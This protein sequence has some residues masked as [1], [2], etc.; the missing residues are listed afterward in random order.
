MNDSERFIKALNDRD[1]KTIKSVPKSDTH[2]HAT[3]GG[4]A[5]YVLSGKV[6]Q[7]PKIPDK[8]PNLEYMLEWYNEHFEPYCQGIE[9]FER[10]IKGAFHQALDDGITDLAL[11]FNISHSAKYDCDIKKYVNRLSQLHQEV[12]PNINFY[13]ELSFS[14][15][16]NNEEVCKTI[17]L[18]LD[19]DFFTSIDLKGNEKEPVDNY[20]EIFK[21]AKNKGLKTKAHVGEFGNPSEII[22]VIEKLNLDEVHHGHQAINS[23]DIMNYLKEKKI[24]LN[25]CPTSNVV[26]GN[27][28]EY[29]NHPIGKLYRYGIPV[30]IN[31][32][33]VLI[34]DMSVSDEYLKLFNEGVLNAK[35]LNEIRLYGLERLRDCKLESK[36]NIKR[37]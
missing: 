3:R 9:G 11:S 16:R 29:K 23:L 35:E 18:I 33:D 10:R 24:T 1:I 14:R 15:T 19:L 37:V 28:D 27:V 2:N 5:K 8:I 26:L 22:D 21:K 13:P 17:D 36:I 7:L 4:N 12:A 30:T 34:F 25:I 31:T 6:K 32:D 20:I